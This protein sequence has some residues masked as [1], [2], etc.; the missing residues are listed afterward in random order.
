MSL[1]EG[2]LIAC[3]VLPWFD[4]FPDLTH[5]DFLLLLQACT[6]DCPEL[7]K[8]Q[9][10]VVRPRLAGGEAKKRWVGFFTLPAGWVSWFGGVAD[11][12]SRAPV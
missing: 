2:Y 1:Q 4:R 3:L 7:R 11:I 12:D 10:S 8:R 5:C 6:M 9:L